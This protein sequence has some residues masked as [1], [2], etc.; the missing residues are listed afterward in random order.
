MRRGLTLLMT[1][2]LLLGLACGPGTVADPAH[3]AGRGERPG[4]GGSGAPDSGLVVHDAGVVVRDAG[5]SPSDAGGPSTSDAGSGSRDAGD[6]D[7]VVRPSPDRP[8]TDTAWSRDLAVGANGP[9]PVIVVDQLGYRPGSQKVAVIRDPQVGYDA[10]VSFSPGS[11]YQLVNH[12]GQI[13]KEGAPV[14]WMGGATDSS[15]GDK[16]WW[17]DFSDVTTQGTYHVVDVEKNARSPEFDIDGDVYRS[18][19]KHAVRMYYYQR[20]G[21]AKSAQTA[22]ADWADGVSHL[23]SGQDGEAHSVVAKSDGSLVRDLRGGWYDAGDFNKYTAWAAQT[24]ITLL[25]AYD[26]HP[27]AFGDDYGIAESGNGIP[28]L[29][30]EVRWALDWIVR[31]QSSDGGLLCVA[32]LASA[33]P[34]SAAKGP[35]YYGPATTNASLMS[36]AAFAYASKVFGGRPEASLKSYAADLK[37]R[38]AKA[39]TWAQANPRVIYY[40]NDES[41]Q[42][43]S[44]G[45]GAG[46]QETDDSGRLVSKVIAAV[47]LY[48]LT[49]DAAYRSVVESNFGSILS[50]SGPNEWDMEKADALLHYAGLTGIS[51]AV[52]STIVSQFVANVGANNT[53][54]LPAVIGQVDPYRAYLHDYT[55]GSN[56]IKMAQARLYQQLARYGSGSTAK[57]AAAAA[58]DYVHYLHG[59]NPLGL[60]YLT[61]LKRAGAEA[62]AKTLYHTWFSDG[63]RWDEVS[64]NTPGPAPGFLV[65]GPNAYFTVDDATLAPPLNQPAQKAYLQYNTGWPQNSWAISEPSTGYQAKYILVLAAFAH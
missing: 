62:S 47:H 41:K 40:N 45:L 5:S 49:G 46:Q 6:A 30:D 44:G 37:S 65:G 52:K 27:T 2:Q 11:R 21:F 57:V 61:N 9:I 14:S 55:W 43:G 24:V 33:S 1:S 59:V 25:H 35:T 18:A 3:D 12:A 8:S 63:T 36:A 42:P 56:Q 53:T 48:G 26:E 13:V 28:D 31:M 58:E 60:V 17:F 20:A 7:T 16:V 29:L 15:S 32:G 23:G 64:D 34:P 38:A 22:G 4:D 51:E 39:W 19:L 10:N 50:S 54:Q